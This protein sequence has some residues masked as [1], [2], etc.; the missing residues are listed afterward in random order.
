ML[1]SQ[2]EKPNIHIKGKRTV[3]LEWLLPHERAS[4]YLPAALGEAPFVQQKS[5]RR[6]QKIMKTNEASAMMKRQPPL[7]ACPSKA[8]HTREK[9]REKAV[10]YYL[11]YFK[12][13]FVPD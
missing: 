12:P 10:Q 8:H 5:D 2:K 3:R 4:V 13:S 1:H 9:E 6:L 11:N 7:T